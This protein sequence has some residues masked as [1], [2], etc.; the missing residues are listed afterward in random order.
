M[1]DPSDATADL[2]MDGLTNVEEFQLGTNPTVIDSDGDKR[3]DGLEDANQNGVLD[4]GESDPTK[5]DTDGDG[6]DDL[7]E[8]AFGTDFADVQSF[9][10]PSASAVGQ[11][12][13]LDDFEN[14]N[15]ATGN[16]GE[17]GGVQ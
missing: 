15:V 8:S 1:D 3:P 2:D 5:K 7:I 14:G 13:I 11:C 17:N 10:D 16:V 6:I 9:P 4:P 12:L